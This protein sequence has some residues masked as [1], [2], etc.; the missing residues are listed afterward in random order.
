MNGQ[1]G[2]LRTFWM[3][4]YQY[5]RALCSGT[6]SL[7]LYDTFVIQECRTG[8]TT[9][10]ACVPGSSQI[11]PLD[12]KCHSVACGL[13]NGIIGN[14]HGFPKETTQFYPDVSHTPGS[15][16]KYDLCQDTL[17]AIDTKYLAA[18]MKLLHFRDGD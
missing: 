7:I 11:G 16:I 14:L 6:C 13:L 12:T 3:E 17:F 18:K 2:Q 4:C 5:Q 10:G 1:I 15:G 8:V 9:Y